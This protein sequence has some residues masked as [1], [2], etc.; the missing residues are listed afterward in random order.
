MMATL[1]GWGGAPWRSWGGLRGRRRRRGLPGDVPC[2]QHGSY[3]GV[4][5]DGALLV[6]GASGRNG[7][8]GDSARRRLPLTLAAGGATERGAEIRLDRRLVLEPA[9][10]A[11]TWRPDGLVGGTLFTPASPG[12]HPAAIVLPGESGGVWLSLAALLASRGYCG[13]GARILRHAGTAAAPRQHSGRVLREGQWPGSS[14][15]SDRARASSPRSASRAGASWRCC[16]ARPFRRSARSSPIAPSGVVFGP[17]GPAEPGDSAWTHRGRPLA[18]LGQSNRTRRLVGHRPA[19]HADRRETP[20]RDRC[21][22][23]ATPSSDPRF[24]VEQHEG[25]GRC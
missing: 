2:P 8:S 18:H 25:T 15:R 17:V 4:S 9:S 3:R 1:G 10:R 7:R 12:P 21:S 6:D 19:A 5:R 13:A 23:T 22:A 24:P 11:A 14:R 20:L 16:W